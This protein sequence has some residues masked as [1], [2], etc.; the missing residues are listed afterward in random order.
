MLRDGAFDCTV[1]YEQLRRSMPHCKEQQKSLCIYK[2][3]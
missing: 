2:V 1:L 3:R